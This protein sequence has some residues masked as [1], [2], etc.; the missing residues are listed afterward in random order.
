CGARG[1][2]AGAQRVPGR[3]AE[4]PGA[5]R[6]I[7]RR[8]RGRLRA[9]SVGDRRDPRRGE[10]GV[11]GASAGGGVPA[12]PVHAD[13]GLRGRFRPF[14]GRCGRGLGDGRVSGAGGADPGGERRTRRG[15]GAGRGRA[16]GP[17]PPARRDDPGSAG[18]VPAPRRRVRAAGRRLDHRG[19][20]RAARTPGARRCGMNRAA[21]RW[22]GVAAA[23]AALSALVAQSPR[24][25]RRL[26]YFAVDQ[27]E[28]TGTRYLA[29][30]AA[31][32]ISGIAAPA[33]VFDDPEPWRQALLAH[34]LVADARIERRLPGTIILRITETEP[35][36]LAR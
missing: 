23:A 18:R 7:R 5:R 33:N 34:P 15:C 22:L 19:R 36:A 17:L 32:S 35:V 8:D 27:V 6:G 9:P 26:E 14:A 13:A 20:A 21:L 28:V 29:P 1:G 4:V 24:L 25:L 3:G 10:E 2:E 12:S 11:P 16:R 31:L 30:E